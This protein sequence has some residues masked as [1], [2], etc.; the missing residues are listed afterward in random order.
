MA[1][2][3]RNVGASVRARLLQLAKASGQSFDLVL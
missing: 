3:I 2:E 1:K